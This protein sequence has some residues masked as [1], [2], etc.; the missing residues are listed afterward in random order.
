MLLYCS[1]Y[2]CNVLTIVN[3]YICIISRMVIYFLL[4]ASEFRYTN[5]HIYVHI[6]NIF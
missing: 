1:Y 2:Y 4:S 5:N 3:V 6:Y